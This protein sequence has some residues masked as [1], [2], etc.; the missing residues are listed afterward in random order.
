[1]S[2]YLCHDF[3]TPR[4][5][6]ARR[7]PNT[8]RFVPIA[9]YVA[10]VTGAYFITMDT[11]GYRAA[12]QD[13]A[14]FD[15]LKVQNDAEKSKYEQD[16]ANVNL[17]TSRAQEVAKWIEGT[18]VIQPVCVKIGR[19]IKGE[20]RLGELIIERNEQ[21]P[22]QIILSM[23]VTGASLTDVAQIQS[24]VEQL[25]YRAYSPQQSKQGDVIDYRSSLVWQQH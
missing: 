11:I 3:K 6:T 19:A 13:K 17:E 22:N 14:H 18:R 2:N 5:D 15:L 7:L 25:N 9:F 4:T 12:K 10:M 20:A 23:K 16:V 24:S 8:F 21:L 1:M